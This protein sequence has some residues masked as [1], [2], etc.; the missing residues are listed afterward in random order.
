MDTTYDNQKIRAIKRKLELVNCLGGKCSRCG[1][2]KSLSALEFHHRNPLEKSFA[3]DSRSIASKRMET[4][5]EEIK[6]CDLLCSNC[7]KEIHY[8]HLNKE[9][10][11]N[12]LN[13]YKIDILQKKSPQHK[14]KYICEY[15]GKP[16]KAVTNKHFCCEECRIKSK[17]YPS[18]E[19]IRKKYEELKG[20]QK[21]AEYFNITR[22]VIRNIR[23]RA[24]EKA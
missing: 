17:N 10:I 2:D 1:Y 5:M 9:N 11:E 12:T 21:V 24:G 19:E 13:G 16:F 18:I 15:C 7:H 3:L 20:W 4:L 14:S 23:R 8:A 22:N 6:K